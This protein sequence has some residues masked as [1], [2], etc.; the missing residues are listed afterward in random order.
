MVDRKEMTRRKELGPDLTLAVEKL[1][2]ERLGRLEGALL[3]GNKIYKKSTSEEAERYLRDRVIPHVTVRL[4]LEKNSLELMETA[5]LM[6][7]LE[8]VGNSPVLLTRVERIVPNGFEL[9]SSPDNY[10]L[11]NTSLDMRGKKLDPHVIE[12][13]HI[14]LRAARKGTTIIAPR[15]LFVSETGRSMSCKPEPVSIEVS[16][17][18][19]PDRVKTGF[20]DLDNLLLGGLPENYAVMLTSDSCDERDLLIRRYLEAGA[21][22]R[23]ATLYVTMDARSVRNL[24]EE[25]KS[26]FRVLVCNSKL[27]EAL[28]GLPNIFGLG[29]VENL[30]EMN[31]AFE[32]VFRKLGKSKNGLGRVC[33]DIV[34]DVLL[35]HH[36]VQTRRWL[37]ALIP[38]LR[39][40][41]FTTL[42]V[43]NPH[44]HAPEELHAVL[45]LFDGEISIYE[46]EEQRSL[47]KYLRI[48]RMHN[49]RY[50][51]NELPLRK[52]RLM[53]TP[54]TLPCCTRAPNL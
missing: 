22:E 11:T 43:M 47:A 27:D 46:K 34:S 48:K 41:G 14:T 32:S 29:G 51:E 10:L 26:N 3:L 50:L 52:T 18:I 16:E 5:N 54:A 38:E 6:V 49:Q 19:L 42:A 1:V 40:K 31:I 37:T 2:K 15:I 12:N 7:E 39:S 24:A 25:F 33:L 9:V 23:N 21:V 13:V 35:Q 20:K 30:T 28:D 36:A 4:A 8:N 53:T 17:T 44:M 45:G